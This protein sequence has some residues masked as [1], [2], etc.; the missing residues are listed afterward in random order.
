MSGRQRREWSS[1]LGA[2]FGVLFVFLY[3]ARYLLPIEAE[4]PADSL[5]TYDNRLA[6]IFGVVSTLGGIFAILFVLSLRAAIP[7]RVSVLT[8]A[9]VVFAIVSAIVPV[10][11]NL[12]ALQATASLAE[13]Y[14]SSTATAVDKAAAVVSERAVE[15]GEEALFSVFIG[16]PIAIGLFS[17]SMLKSKVFPQWLTYEG[18]AFSVGTGVALLFVAAGVVPP[19]LGFAFLGLLFLWGLASSAYLWRSDRNT[20]TTEPQ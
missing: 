5:A 10:V 11:V 13:V 19:G 2:L 18:F 16:T 15:A 8:T 17:G 3:I 6:I 1:R 9:A 14:N 12:A 7:R 20:A 4:T